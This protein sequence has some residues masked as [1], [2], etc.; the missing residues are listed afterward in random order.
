M[1]KF[2]VYHLM[3]TLI[4]LKV[5]KDTWA[6]WRINSAEVDP[7]KVVT[8]YVKKYGVKVNVQR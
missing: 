7:D 1:K 5:A 2:V 3:E 6:D 4:N 8:T